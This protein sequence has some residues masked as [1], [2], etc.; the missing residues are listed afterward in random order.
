V[1]SPPPAAGA[2]RFTHVHELPP[3]GIR[4]APPTGSPRLTWQQAVVAGED[5]HGDWG[6]G[7]SPEGQLADDRDRLRGPVRPV[8]A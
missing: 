8:L 1:T 6:S 2:H 3:L 7:T 5:L 4:I